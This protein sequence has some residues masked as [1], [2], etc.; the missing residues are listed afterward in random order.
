MWEV[1]TREGMEGVDGADADSGDDSSDD[2]AAA[3]GRQ[4]SSGTERKIDG[5][6][7]QEVAKSF[8]NNRCDLLWQGLLPKRSFTGFKF[9]ESQTEAAARKMMRAKGLGHYWDMVEGADAMLTAAA[10]VALSLF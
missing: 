1:N 8:A 9:Q 4:E 10:P 6:E 2:E 5:G 3:A 7:Q